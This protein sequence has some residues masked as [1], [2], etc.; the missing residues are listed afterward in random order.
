MVDSWIPF[1][2]TCLC[3]VSPYSAIFTDT[4]SKQPHSCP[5]PISTI[6][7]YE[8]RRLL[9]LLWHAQVPPCWAWNTS[10]TPQLCANNPLRPMPPNNL[11]LSE[12]GGTACRLPVCL[13]I[14]LTSG[15]D[16]QL[17]L[18]CLWPDAYHLLELTKA[19]FCSFPFLWFWDSCPDPI[20]PAF[21]LLGQSLSW[22]PTPPVTPSQPQLSL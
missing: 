8:S 9:T 7:P 18:C 22:Q 14:H 17:C 12:L 4:S 10:N 11:A 3:L 2:S 6:A 1:C 21:Q 5:P 19:G 13:S 20:C 15:E 16:T